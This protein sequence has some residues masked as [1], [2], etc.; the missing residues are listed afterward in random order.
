M[1]SLSLIKA[2]DGEFH[3]IRVFITMLFKKAKEKLEKVQSR[4]EEV[5]KI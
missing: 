2:L 1:F 3:C 5:Q 4:D